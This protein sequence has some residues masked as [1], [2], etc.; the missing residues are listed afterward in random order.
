[1]LLGWLTVGLVVRLLNISQ[2]FSDGWSWREADVAMIAENFYRHGF[3]LFYPQI[4]WAGNAPGYVGTEFQLVPF[5]ASLLYIPFGAQEWIGRSVSVLFFGV[6]VPF[7]YLLVKKVANERS[8][9]WATGMYTLVPLNIFAS[10]SFMPDIA[11]LSFSIAALYLFAEWLE[12]ERSAWL[13]AATSLATSLAILVKLPAV[14]IGLPLAY[15]AWDKHGV[16]LVLRSQLWGFAALSLLFPL[17]WY[18]HA[19]LLSKSHFPYHFFGDGGITIEGLDWYL[20]I[21]HRTATASLTPIVFAAM[22]VGGIATLHTACSRV[23]HWWLLAILFFT[24]MA[25]WGNRHEW[26]QLPLVPV[27]TAL[28]GMAGDMTYRRCT[29]LTGSKIARF[30]TGS[31]F[32]AALASLSYISVTPLYA[33]QRPA[34]WK[35]GNALNRLTPPDALVLVADDGDPRA[36]YYSKRRGWH[37]LQDGLLKGYPADSQ[38]AIAWLEKFRKAGASYLAFPQDALWWFEH[39]KGFQEYLDSRYRRQRDTD[40]YIFNVSVAKPE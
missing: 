28:A 35:V 29:G 5:I 37:F 6:S 17:A 7:F 30:L 8:A 9:L 1:M 13:F 20:G 36:I 24:I 15:M 39:Y 40:E 34:L 21:L 23:F 26:Y 12:H 32:W 11:S 22:L 27:A 16:R 25:G 31:V 33:H 4:N 2:P 3:H 18:V 14:V 38:Q 19:Y 10:R